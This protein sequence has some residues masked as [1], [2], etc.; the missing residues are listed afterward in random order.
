M[1]LLVTLAA[2]CSP[3]LKP[4]ALSV[5]FFE[6]RG[7]SGPTLWK[8]ALCLTCTCSRYSE[9]YSSWPLRLQ[10]SMQDTKSWGGQREARLSD[11]GVFGSALPQPTTRACGHRLGQVG[12]SHTNKFH[13]CELPRVLCAHTRVSVAPTGRFHLH[14]TA[15]VLKWAYFVYG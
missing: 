6:P 8:P 12:H 7:G 9:A 5:P 10:L 4:E 3:A 1:E 2:V 13:P 11:P 15:Q 14:G